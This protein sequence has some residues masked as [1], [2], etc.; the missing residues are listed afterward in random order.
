MGVLGLC[1][2]RSPDVG[3]QPRRLAERDLLHPDEEAAIIAL[4]GTDAALAAA[5]E[6]VRVRRAS[7]G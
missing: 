7:G 2:R 1:H 4:A 5:A 6:V 3:D